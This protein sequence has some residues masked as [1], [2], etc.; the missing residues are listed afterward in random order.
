MTLPAPLPSRP[1]RPPVIGGNRPGINNPG[2]IIIGGNN[3]NNVIINN[4]Y[5]GWP[6]GN[7]WG[8]G[9]W[10]WNRPGW[11]N[12]PS[13]GDYW[14]QNHIHAHHHGWYHGCWSGNWYQNWYTPALTFATG[15]GLGNL[16]ARTTWQSWSN[17][18]WVVVNQPV[19][20]YSRPIF[21]QPVAAPNPADSV[22]REHDQQRALAEFDEAIAYF[23]SRNYRKALERCDSALR[24]LPSD[25]VI[26]EV[27]ALALFALGEYREAAAIL[28]ALLATSPG[29]DWTSM[30]QI[31]ADSREYTRHLASLERH[32]KRQPEDSAAR[33]LLAYHYLVTGETNSAIEA[34]R[35]VIAR[36]PSDRT[37]RQLLEALI[38]AQSPDAAGSRMASPTAGNLPAP[39]PA[40]QNPSSPSGNEPQANRPAIE[41]SLSGQWMATSEGTTVRLAVQE[42]GEFTWT[43]E[44]KGEQPVTVNGR[45]SGSSDMLVLESG[46]AGTMIARVEPVSTESF[47]FQLLGSGQSPALLFERR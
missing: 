12:Y 46:S 13:W 23:Q 18:Y 37:S 39:E 17:P 44:A 15:W 43:V 31:Y 29:M 47:R 26:H 3:N 25:P 36:E 40:S 34:L 7:N 9:N 8:H 2:G 28:N 33:F 42:N 41:L 6:G 14:Y 38:A 22:I 10:G 35:Q 24:V 45:I 11:G 20:D 21:V 1:G 4:N 5:W 30:S 27:R 32:V 16:Y 19:Y